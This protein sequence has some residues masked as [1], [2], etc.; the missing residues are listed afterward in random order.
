MGF[1]AIRQLKYTGDNYSFESPYFDDG[2]VLIEGDNGSGKTTFCDL[3][4]YALGGDVS[5]FRKDTPK[6]HV[7]IAADLNNFVELCI[8]INGKVYWLS[9]N[10]GENAISVF[11]DAGP[12][13]YPIDRHGDEPIFSD[14]ILGKLGI[15]VV[16]IYQGAK[17]FKSNL[18]DMFRLI[19][20][21]QNPD[22]KTVLK[23]SDRDGYFYDTLEMK[24][25]IFQ[26]LVGEVFSEYYKTVGLQKRAEASKAASKILLD[27]QLETAKI[28]AKGDDQNL[29]VLR[30]KLDEYDEQ[31]EKLAVK[32]KDLRRIRTSTGPLEN[33]EIFKSELVEQEILSIEL[34]QQKT[35]HISELYMLSE[36]RSRAIEEMQ[37]INKII[38]SHERLNLFSPDTCPYCL[39]SVVREEGHCVCGG[40][41]EES[42]YERFFTI[43]KSI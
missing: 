18:Y 12:Q 36:V 37:R 21:N 6:K 4:Y 40:V 29:E 23:Q 3:L 35:K 43:K 38:F 34:Q 24:K 1:L 28:L 41:V 17:T 22:P 8:E 9:R 33:L 39:H 2:L 42:A 31:I 5:Q 7:E 26:I 30:S 11:E 27:E 13:L 10:F 20:Y 14:F 25:S 19:Y 16:D 15:G 32:R